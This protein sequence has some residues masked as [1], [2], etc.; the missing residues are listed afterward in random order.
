VNVSVITHDKRATDI[1]AYDSH[2]FGWLYSRKHWR[3][4]RKL[5][6]T[7]IGCFIANGEAPGLVPVNIRIII[8]LRLWRRWVSR[9]GILN[10][11]EDQQAVYWDALNGF[12]CVDL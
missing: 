5:W 6:W 3:R 10:L 1:E 9:M 12:G 8:A 11:A 4:R 7:N 2:I